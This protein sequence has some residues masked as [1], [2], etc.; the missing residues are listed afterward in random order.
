MSNYI[1]LIRKVKNLADRGVN[2]EKEN[3]TILLEKLMKKYGV[4]FDQIEVPERKL[5]KFYLRG[6]KKLFFQ[7]VWSIVEGWSGTY[8][9]DKTAVW[10]DVTA[11][12]KIQIEYKFDLMLKALKKEQALLLR[13]FI[14]KNELHSSARNYIKLSDLTPEEFEEYMRIEA[15][16]RGIE[17]VNVMKQLE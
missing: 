13:A 17:R 7:T 10:L 6:Q 8:Y 16:A 9:P 5:A 14:K 12:E 3:A 15:M 4:S 11:A 1:D 2:G